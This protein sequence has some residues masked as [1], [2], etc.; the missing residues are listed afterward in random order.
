[1]GL[2]PL[3]VALS[4]ALFLV[5]E[6]EE[7]EEI[8][9][10]T[11][12]LAAAHGDRR[13]EWLASIQHV[14][15]KDSL[16]PESWNADEV[17]GTAREALAVFEELDDD[18]GLARAWALAGFVDWNACRFELAAKA[19]ERGLAHARR[20]GDERTQDY[21]AGNLIAALYYG[22]TPVPEAIARI[23][24]L[25]AQAR[26]RALEASALKQL[27]G[28]HTMQGHFDEGRALYE[29]SKAICREFGLTLSLATATM[30][31]REI[32]LLA[33]DVEGAVRELRW[34]YETLAE[35]GEKGRRSTLAANLAEALY[36]QRRYEEA[37]HFAR[38]SLEAASS[39]DIASQV[40]GQMV[41]AKLLAVEGKHDDAEQAARDAAALAEKTDDLFTLGQAYE[42]LADVLLLAGR[43]EGAIVALEAAA[44]SSERKGNLVT[45]ANASAVLASLRPSPSPGATGKTGARG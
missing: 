2:P 13:T 14:L 8:C 39:E 30:T 4:E 5:G 37:D 33:G 23:E 12:D 17:R 34:G 15:L 28:L 1:V 24:A 6:L 25:L 26:S 44:E 19:Y 29:Q 35:M 41:K 21:L 38:A 20:S 40:M 7:S 27:A 31:V 32:H 3:G 42:A 43:R 45:A 22:A 36:R 11:M 9:R 16:E 10:E 18:R